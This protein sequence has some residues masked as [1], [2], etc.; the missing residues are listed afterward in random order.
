MI[1]HRVFSNDYKG[2]FNINAS[3]VCVCVCVCVCLCVSVCVSVCGGVGGWVGE[4]LWVYL[5]VG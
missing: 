5:L 3:C 2:Y 4:C 1:K